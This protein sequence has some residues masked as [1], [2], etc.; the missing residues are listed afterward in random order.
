MSAAIETGVEL[1]AARKQ[2]YKQAGLSYYRPWIF[3]I[4]DGAPTD[5]WKRAV[6]LVRGGEQQKQFS[7]FAVGVEGAIWRRWT[8]LQPAQA[9]VEIEWP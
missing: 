8:D 7:F 5:N 1:L 2:T 4:T 6:E 3:L 9:A